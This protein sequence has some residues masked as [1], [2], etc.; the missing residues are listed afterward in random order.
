M[1][2]SKKYIEIRIIAHPV[3]LSGFIP[4]C[5]S[6]NQKKTAHAK[7]MTA[8]MAKL[9]NVAN[10]L[11]AGNKLNKNASERKITDRHT[12]Q[13]SI[14]NIHALEFLF[15]ESLHPSFNK[16]SPQISITVAIIRCSTNPD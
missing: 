5:R 6:R 9:K 7:L 3:I 4:L 13:G 8:K 11:D 2:I 12:G 15:E 1:T 16:C 14:N 10:N